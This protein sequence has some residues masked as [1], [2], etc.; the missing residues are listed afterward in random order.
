MNK[1]FFI[2]ILCLLGLS[3]VGCSEDNM[4]EAQ[5]AYDKKD[6]A[7]AID[8]Y[9]KACDAKDAE[10][11]AIV[12]DMYDE[13]KGVKWDESK[14]IQF[15]VKACDGKNPHGFNKLG[16]M[17]KDGRQ[18][19]ISNSKAS[20]LFVEACEGNNAEGCRN[21]GR[22]YDLGLGI[23]RDRSKV[24]DFYSKACELNDSKG[25]S[26]LVE[27]YDNGYG[28][29]KDIVKANKFSLLAIKLAT[30]GCDREDE[31]ECSELSK[32]MRNEGTRHD[33]YEEKY[34]T[35]AAEIDDK[36]LRLNIKSCNEGNLIACGY[37]GEMYA[38][39]D[40]HNT[41][42][43]NLLNKACDGGY[44]QSCISL[45][46]EHS[47]F[48]HS[49]DGVPQINYNLSKAHQ[50][51]LKACDLG[52]TEGC[53]KIAENYSSSYPN[54]ADIPNA[55]K[56]Y[57]KACDRGDSQGCADLGH[58]YAGVQELGVVEAFGVQSSWRSLKPDYKKAN[59]YYSKA[60]DAGQAVI[61]ERLGEVYATGF[62]YNGLRAGHDYSKGAEFFTKACNGGFGVGCAYLGEM[63]EKGI[64]VKK[65]TSKSLQLYTR[66]C[67][68]EVKEACSMISQP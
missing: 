60:C 50:A 2:L 11:C 61:C 53:N 27:I 36:I 21:L 22:M 7:V 14:S 8:L 15:Y 38:N 18:V 51:Y 37:V 48:G 46:F 35:K 30:Q 43:I 23:E 32:I 20:D 5:Q 41:Q 67:D 24:I 12:G 16:L 52:N 9:T 39:G 49:E 28:V 56:F 19:K 29:K 31:V 64:G 44:A 10:A 3:I 13:G 45:G 65:D 59:E 4:V 40:V 62:V 34:F 1:F 17:Y 42:G 33:K 47:R 68:F 58:I 57:T 54:G 55:I 66:A 26:N 25:C 63:Y 6:Y